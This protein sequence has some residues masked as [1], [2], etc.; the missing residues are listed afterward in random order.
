M[1]EEE[2]ESRSRGGATKAKKFIEGK[3]N[4]GHNPVGYIL[5]EN[6]LKKRPVFEPIIKDAFTSFIN[7]RNISKVR[8][9]INQKYSLKLESR[10]IRNILTDPVYIGEPKY[11]GVSKHDES[12]IFIEKGL[13]FEANALLSEI[14]ERYSR[15][16][17]I[18]CSEIIAQED[19]DILGFLRRINTHAK[20]CGGE[21][22]GNGTTL[23]DGEIRV[24]FK[25]NKCDGQFRLPLKRRSYIRKD[26]KKT[27][28]EVN[29]LNMMNVENVSIKKQVSKQSN[30]KK[31]HTDG[32]PAN[33]GL[34]KFF[35][36]KG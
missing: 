7:K 8:D 25:C 29:P 32:L 34:D 22:V 11:L 17:A 26:M 3:W 2:N 15:R 9:K 1:A 35:Q 14:E 20:N 12:L 28:A 21:W 6:W 30:M 19:M 31:N 33:G 27:V 16:E 24:I 18:T 13:F 10:H 36:V 5:E 4:K 23:V